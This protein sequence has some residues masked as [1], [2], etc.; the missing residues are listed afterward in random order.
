M[1]NFECIVNPIF[2]LKGDKCALH[3]LYLNDF[4]IKHHASS[5]YFLCDYFSKWLFA[6]RWPCYFG[7]ELIK[8]LFKLRPRQTLDN[9]RGVSGVATSATPIFL[10]N[11]T[12]LSS[13][14]QRRCLQD[15]TLAFRPE[16]TIP[17]L[18]E[19]Q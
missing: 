3:E 9:S 8:P 12:M 7:C 16:L 19:N 4:G 17:I 18:E 2:K 5:W 1:E 11:L 6:N 10:G 15:S 13:I 14:F